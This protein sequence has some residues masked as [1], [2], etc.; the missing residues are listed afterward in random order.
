[1]AKRQ[2]AKVFAERSLLKRKVPRRVSSIVKKFPNIGKDIEDFVRNKRCGADSWRR[3]G[4]ATF[5]G[6]RKRGPKASFRS[7]QEYLQNKYNTKIGY[8]TIVQMCVVRNRR[9]LSAKR[10]K[11]EAKTSSK[12]SYP[13][14]WR[15]LY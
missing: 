2:Q 5:D 14:Q 3:T 13:D 1:M 7:I 6:N 4:V 10:Y 12:S 15:F 9:K 8:G 11:G